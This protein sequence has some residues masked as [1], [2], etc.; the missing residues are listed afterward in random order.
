MKMLH[1]LRVPAVAVVDHRVVVVRHRAR[2][3]HVDPV[4]QRGLDETVRERV[5]CLSVRA[6]QELPLRAASRDQIELARQNWARQHAG[7]TIKISASRLRCDLAPLESPLAGYRPA[8]SESR[9]TDE[10]W[11]ADGARPE[12]RN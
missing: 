9:T 7:L 2:Q 10:A 1:E 12:V 4:S 11:S 8:L 6:Q 3:Q 5:I